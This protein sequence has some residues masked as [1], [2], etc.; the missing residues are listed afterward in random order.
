MEFKTV[1]D[2]Y[3]KLFASR[4]IQKGELLF[5]EQPLA[6]SITANIGYMPWNDDIIRQCSSLKG[7]NAIRFEL[8]N[9]RRGTK[10][11]LPPIEILTENA[12]KKYDK[13][14]LTK[15]QMKL[16]LKK[17]A[18]T[19]QNIGQVPYS[20]KSVYYSVCSIMPFVSHDTESNVYVETP[21]LR[22]TMAY[23]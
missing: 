15:S 2:D 4:D 3:P 9:N 17:K 5:A 19:K 18:F 20:N 23:A 12:Y 22:L 13:F 6:T 1:Q 11:K 16:I 7:V 14:G 10:N 8:L 21:H